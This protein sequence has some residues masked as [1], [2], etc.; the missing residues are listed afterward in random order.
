MPAS[1]P[2]RHVDASLDD[3]VVPSVPTHKLKDIKAGDNSVQLLVSTKDHVY[4]ADGVEA[5]V[6]SWQV[7][8]AW[9]ESALAELSKFLTIRQQTQAA[10]G[11]GSQRAAFGNRFGGGQKLGSQ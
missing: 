6:D 9:D 10:Q 7:I 8:G 4:D 1:A 2:D 3:D 5:G 11:S